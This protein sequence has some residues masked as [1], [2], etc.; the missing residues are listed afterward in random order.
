MAGSVPLVRISSV[1][2]VEVV[3]DVDGPRPGLCGWDI[4]VE[5]N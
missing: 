1:S 5:G 3:R 4:Y 2:G